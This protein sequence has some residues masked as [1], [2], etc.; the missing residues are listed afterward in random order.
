MYSHTVNV[1]PALISCL[2]WEDSD[3]LQSVHD[4]AYP[5]DLVWG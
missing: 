4:L 5:L 1:F 2:L 3:T